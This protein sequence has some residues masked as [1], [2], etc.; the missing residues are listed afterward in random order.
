LDQRR[1]NEEQGS[2][3]PTQ[4]TSIDMMEYTGMLRRRWWIVVAL[5]IFGTVGGFAYY[6]ISP[7]IYNAT[8]AVNVLRTGANQSDQ[9]VGARA[10]GAVDLNS[11]A[12]LVTSATV[13]AAAGKIMKSPLA[14]T[15]LAH[16]ITITVPPNSG[17]LDITCGERTPAAAA[18]CANAFAAAYL[19][20]RAT[21]AEDA[22]ATQI[23]NLT[24]EI[25]GLQKNV[26]SLNTVIPSLPGNSLT[27]ISDEANLK[28]DTARINSLTG[29]VSALT[30]QAAS[31]VGGTVI[32]AATPPG[33][34]AEPDRTLVVPSAVASGL[35][36]GLMGAWFYDRRDNRMRTAKDVE[37]LLDIPVLLDLPRKSFGRQISLAS[38]RSRIGKSF[39]ELAHSVAASLGEGSHILLVAGTEPGPEASIVAANLAAT[40]ARTHSEAVLVCADLND[41]VATDLF[42]LSDSRGL[43][44][45]VAGR[46]T[47]GE[48]ARGPAGIPGLWVIP[49]GAD[50]SLAEY[51]LQH[52]TAKAL[53]SQL[54]RDARYVIIEAQATDD[55]TDTLAL[56]EFADAALLTVDVNRTSRQDATSCIRRLHRMRTPILGAVT[57]PPLD[58]HVTIRPPQPGSARL[59][60]GQ[61]DGREGVTGRVHG[62]LPGA[63]SAPVRSRDGHGDPADRVSGR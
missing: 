21:A 60:S 27:R 14:P 33:K 4:P 17:V 49:P 51:H 35:L 12:Q 58:S 50:T 32:T 46:A 57:L 7:K 22:D 8:A 2:M 36:L 19:D 56:A 18:T 63:P 54:R 11:E 52:D 24:T 31:T 48:V 23:K 26:D 38:P 1:E 30:G 9:V 55:G 37:R 53:T 29:Q 6:Q 45:V 28:S 13:A 42:G 5:T 47:V 15:A 10:G 44:E 62:E 20:N 41:S 25:G 59:S 39:T 34:S 61:P 43:A 16:E 3:K 40:L